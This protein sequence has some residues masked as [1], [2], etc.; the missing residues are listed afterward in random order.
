MLA[1]AAYSAALN[2]CGALRLPGLMAQLLALYV[3]LRLPEFRWM[4]VAWLATTAF[5]FLTAG[6]G[7]AQLGTR[8]FYPVATTPDTWRAEIAK[9]QPQHLYLDPY[10]LCSVYDYRMPPDSTAYS[11][12]LTYIGAW[13]PPDVFPP[14]SAILI[15]RQTLCR[16][17][18]LPEGSFPQVPLPGFARAY[19]SAAA[20]PFDLVLIRVDRKPDGTTGWSLVDPAP[21]PSKNSP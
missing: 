3:L 18:L 8:F 21:N 5:F 7:L 1:L 11:S 14:G 20:N 15:A 9:L 2:S 17:S 6:L 13:P 19:P 10:A 16:T 12:S 4:T